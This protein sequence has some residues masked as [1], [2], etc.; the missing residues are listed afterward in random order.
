MV[1]TAGVY[2]VFIALLVVA[3]VVDLRTLRIPDVVIAALFVAW[4][5]WRATVHFQGITDAPVSFS[6]GVIGAIMLGGGLL[7]VTTL[8]EM[9]T[10]KRAMGGG[11]IKLLATVGLYLGIT[12]GL[13]CLLVSCCA[14]LILALVLPRLGW[15]APCSEEDLATSNDVDG[16]GIPDPAKPTLLKDVPF[17][18]A[19]LA[20]A[21]AT[22]LVAVVGPPF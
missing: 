4:F 7:L 14:S 3:T 11:D 17:G 13:F 16:D 5:A 12:G 2:L 1:L 19:I 15:V 8:Y 18:P 20:G 21:L 6:Q 9:V 10:H 22:I